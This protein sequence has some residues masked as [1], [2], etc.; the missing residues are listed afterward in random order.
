MVRDLLDNQVGLTPA[1]NIGP[2]AIEHLAEDRVE[3]LMISSNVSL[4][5]SEH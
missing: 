4:T 5:T 3:R 1:S 2:H